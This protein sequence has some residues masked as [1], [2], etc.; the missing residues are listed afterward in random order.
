MWRAAAVQWSR[1]NAGIVVTSVRDFGILPMSPSAARYF[2]QH[3]DPLEGLPGVPRDAW[4]AHRHVP[5][6]LA[7]MVSPPEEGITYESAIRWIAA[8]DHEDALY[9]TSTTPIM[10]FSGADL[11]ATLHNLPAGAVVQDLSIDLSHVLF[12]TARGTPYINV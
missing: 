9:T 7:T 6:V 8:Q 3:I 1:G 10:Q 5:L 11:A 4:A 12:H 2:A